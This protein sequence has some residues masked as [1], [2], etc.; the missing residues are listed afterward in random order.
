VRVYRAG[1]EIKCAELE[2]ELQDFCHQ[3]K[4]GGHE[5]QVGESTLLL[6]MC[7]SWL[8]VS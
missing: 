2:F 7:Q 5:D 4:Q 8:L 3:R 6:K 1:E